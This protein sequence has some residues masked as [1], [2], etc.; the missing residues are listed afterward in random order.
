MTKKE[1]KPQQQ[2]AGGHRCSMQSAPPHPNMEFIHG[3]FN[4]YEASRECYNLGGQLAVLSNPVAITILKELITYE[5][6]TGDV[7]IG[8]YGNGAH[9]TWQN[10]FENVVYTDWKPGH[11]VPNSDANVSTAVDMI[12]GTWVSK[13]KSTR[14]PHALCQCK[15][16]QVNVLRLVKR[17]FEMEFLYRDIVK[18]LQMNHAISISLRQVKRYLKEMNLARRKDYSNIRS[19]FNFVHTQVTSYG[20]A[21]GYRWMYQKCK[22]HGFKIKETTLASCLTQLIQMGYI[23]EPGED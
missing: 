7:W 22:R 20:P 19:V 8:L 3:D 23:L 18:I 6:L 2:T 21:H 9:L 12:D 1:N 17:Y 15:L 5:P 16:L 14:L 10:M 13:T 4:F 11:T